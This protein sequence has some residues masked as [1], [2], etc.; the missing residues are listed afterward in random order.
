MFGA[1]RKSMAA[2]SP[3]ETRD[4][5]GPMFEDMTQAIV[6]SAPRLLELSARAYAQAFTEKDCATCWPSRR[7]TPAGR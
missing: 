2:R 4:L 5:V 3:P 1:M 6:A 7:A